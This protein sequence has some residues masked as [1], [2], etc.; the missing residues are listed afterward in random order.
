MNMNNNLEK[1]N[2]GLLNES[3]IFGEN[4]SLII[5]SFGT[6]STITDFAIL[7]CGYVSHSSF[8]NIG[9]CYSDSSCYWWTSTTNGSKVL[10]V[11]FFG[12]KSYHDVADFGIG[13]RPAVNMK[14]INVDEKNTK[15]LKNGLL[16]MQYGEYPQTAVMGYVN[17]LLETAYIEK[18]IKR[19]KKNYTIEAYD[20]QRIYPEYEFNGKKF[21]RFVADERC[22]GETLSTGRLISNRAVYWVQVEPIKWI[23][24]ENK[25][26]ALSKK[27]ILAGIKIGNTNIRFDQYLNV[28]F[29]NDIIPSVC[30]NNNYVSTFRDV[31]YGNIKFEDLYVGKPKRYTYGKKNNK[32]NS[33]IDKK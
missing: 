22:C 14:S 20:G 16:E 15:R 25:H 5:D 26:I 12:R 1:N 19:T 30:A 3:G 2:F 18:T 10:A 4:K 24:D 13:I 6:K 27:T 9:G 7:L 31:S 8:T 11:D 21:I 17:E 23:V 29:A 32:L 33:K 28:V